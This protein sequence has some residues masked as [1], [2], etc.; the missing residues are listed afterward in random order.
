LALVFG[1]KIIFFNFSPR[2]TL[3]INRVVYN[4]PRL[5]IPNFWIKTKLDKFVDE[6]MPEI[7]NNARNREYSDDH[8]TF[9]ESLLE[10]EDKM[11]MRE[12]R[13]EIKGF[14]M[15]VSLL[16]IFLLA[17]IVGCRMGGHTGF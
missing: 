7:V 17:L 8:F 9:V 6:L 16:G 11:R 15:A 10:N 14:I 5:I 3:L 1:V 12:I 4:I 2:E 13:K